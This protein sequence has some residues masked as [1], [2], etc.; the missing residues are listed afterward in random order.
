V[1]IG[2][3]HGPGIREGAY[4]A[5]T[6]SRRDAAWANKGPGDWQ[7]ASTFTYPNGKRSLVTQWDDGRWRL[8]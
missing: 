5:G 2:H 8:T 7:P 3:G 6:L 4:M 1:N